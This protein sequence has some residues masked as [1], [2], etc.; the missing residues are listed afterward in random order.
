MEEAKELL[1]TRAGRTPATSHSPIN[2]L[3]PET[4]PKASDDEASDED[5][6]EGPPARWK[7]PV[8]AQDCESASASSV[9]Q[10]LRLTTKDPDAAEQVGTCRWEMLA[11]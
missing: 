2:V 10:W 1:D 3:D 8:S 5:D 6:D 11:G 7:E 4:W 9:L